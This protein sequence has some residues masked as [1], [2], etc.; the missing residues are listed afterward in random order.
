MNMGWNPTFKDRRRAYEVHILDFDA[1]IYG[2]TVKIYFVDR[3]RPEKAFSNVDELKT[4]IRMDVQR[5]RDLLTG[6]PLI[7]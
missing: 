2:E 1:D 7:P 6:A 3:L 4:Q 5:G